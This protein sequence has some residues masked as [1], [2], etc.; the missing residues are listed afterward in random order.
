M[1]TCRKYDWVVFPCSLDQAC[2]YVT[3]LAERLAYS[4]IVAYYSAVV[5]MHVCKG[6]EPIRVSDPIL[7]ATL[8]GIARVKGRGNDSK[9]PI[10]P[11]HLKKMSKVVN[12]NNVWELL[13]FVC[14]LVLFRTLLRISN[15]VVSDHSILRSDLMFNSKGCMFGV[16]SSKTT[17]KSGPTQYLPVMLAD[18]PDICA[19]RWLRKF[20]A[21]HPVMD[22][23]QLFSVEGKGLTYNVFSNRFKN[24]LSKAGIEGNYASHSLRRGGATYM[25]MIDCTVPEIKARGGWKSDCVYRYIRQPMSHKLKVEKLVSSAVGV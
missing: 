8:E 5:Y 18:D 3:Y 21:H 10:L 13:T 12:V 24:L 19:V 7:K 25:S 22:S 16:R 2:L 1:K 14:A 20:L 23:D 9:D 15:A 17:T 11:S 4:S 6:L